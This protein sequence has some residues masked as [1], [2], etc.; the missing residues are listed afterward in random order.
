M[1]VLFSS[2]SNLE[3]K[4][5][6]AT[7]NGCDTETSIKKVLFLDSNF[8]CNN[9]FSYSYFITPSTHAEADINQVPLNG[10]VDGDLLKNDSDDEGDYQ[11]ITNA[12]DDLGNP[13]MLNGTPN[14]L[15]SGANL[16]LLSSGYYYF[17]AGTNVSGQE[18]ITYE[19]CDNATPSSCVTEQLVIQVIPDPNLSGN[20]NPIAHDDTNTV[21]QGD[22]VVSN[23][24]INDLDIDYDPLNIIGVDGTSSTGGLLMVSSVS[25]TLTTV[26]DANGTLAGTAYYN[27]ITGQLTFNADASF[28]GKVPFTY[29]VS[30]GMGGTDN[31]DVTISVEIANTMDN[32]V[33][34]NDDTSLGFSGAF[35]SNSLLINDYDPDGNSITLTSA[36]GSTGTITVGG[37]PTTLGS[38]GSISL[39]PFGAFDYSPANGF[40]GTEV[41]F[42]TICDNG[43]P[44]ACETASLYLTTL[45]TNST[46]AKADFA[47]TLLNTPYSANVLLNDEDA[48][49]DLQT[50]TIAT[51]MP[52]SEGAVMLM[53]DGTYTFTPADGF[54]GET[55]FEY[56][57]CDSGSPQACQVEK[58]TIEIL[59]TPTS[60]GQDPVA[61]FDRN[62]I[63]KC[64]NATGDILSNDFDPDGSMIVVD[65]LF[66]DST[67]D[68][69]PDSIGMVDS[70]LIVAGVHAE[71]FAVT[72]AGE[73]TIL[74][75]GSYTYIPNPGFW[76]EV[77]VNYEIKD[78][79]DDND[80]SMLVIEVLP[81]DGTNTTFAN[82][83]AGVTD[84][85]ILLS[86]ELLKN[87]HDPQ[88][89]DQAITSIYVDV[90]GGGLA[91]DF[92]QYGTPTSVYGT[93]TSGTLVVAG[94]LDILPN[95]LYTF[96]PA[97]D[98]IGNVVSTYEVCD[99][100][101]PASCDQATLSIN[102]VDA[103]RDYGDG[104]P[105][106]P[107]AWHRGIE[108][109]TGNSIPNGTTD[110]WLGLQADLESSPDTSLLADGDLYDDGM[111]FGT[112]P[113]DFPE[114][115]DPNRSY[116]VNITLNSTNPTT[117]YYGMW[118]DYDTDGTFDQFY[119][120]SEM[121]A[122]PVT[123]VV[124]ITTPPTAT[125]SDVTVRLRV[126]DDPLLADDFG[127]GKTNGE[128]ED[129]QT[130]VM[131]PVE[132]AAFDASMDGCDAILKWTTA[133][134]LNSDKFE[135]EHSV[136]GLEFKTI[137][138]MMA[139][140]N[141]SSLN[142]YRFVDFNTAPG[143]NYYRLKQIDV[144]QTYKYSEMAVAD[145]ECEDHID[146]KVYP[147]PTQGQIFVKLSE[148]TDKDLI[149]EIVL[150]DVLGRTLEVIPVTN[151][152]GE[153][154]GIDLSD[155]NK[156]MYFIRVKRGNMIYR[157][158]KVMKW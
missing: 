120:G 87:D 74:E 117:V 31:G 77:F 8:N 152:P 57:V 128:V 67:G 73:L 66:F 115:I 36:Q 55:S 62:Q 138:T 29:T 34:A 56:S 54:V 153:T 110:V 6:E 71:G 44:Q 145:N 50:T 35:Q 113:G 97:P 141:S 51:A 12:T 95:G 112:N 4:Q 91:D 26:Y 142:E 10:F 11:S 140:G 41:V 63:T 2:I 88:L 82:D 130:L 132:L 125:E 147:N 102:V 92:M 23:L 122:S 111:T 49:G 20:N 30:D 90:D 40:V 133:S 103:R 126:D 16:I 136:D 70:V 156:G 83:D 104:P 155:Y 1:I 108:E 25:S 43:S 47:N 24:I 93:D 158:H 38:G 37:P 48:E 14:V 121:T 150:N 118:I 59:P 9:P 99:P 144:N 135:I 13:L 116:N 114:I 154:I 148:V 21:E 94:V 139:T 134:E 127:G 64:L 100:S 119:S 101:T 5:S 53:T 124:T 106:Y 39:Y 33:Y 32:D 137:G 65:S 19:V 75:D 17:V 42:Y 78:E 149:S 98:F 105:I 131:L 60:A 27:A 84:R 3:A 107:E 7:D 81:N 52:A 109:S 96:D 129:Y 79:N 157:T 18:K 15:A 58:V 69:I 151:S 22:Q 68:G 28:E 85:D 61:N 143:L 46:S 76:G 80:E 146:V 89:Q 86:G 72:N 123:A 45:A